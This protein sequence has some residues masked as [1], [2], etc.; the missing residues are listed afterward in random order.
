MS[1]DNWTICP[2]CQKTAL[3]A[4]ERDREK[5]AKQYGKIEPVE[6]VKRSAEVDKPIELEETL[7]EDYELGL[8]EG[9]FYISYRASCAQ[10]GF[11]LSYAREETVPDLID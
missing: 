10:C 8:F 11:E 5:L 1:A 2:R 9:Q 6:F 4:K 3:A 7:R